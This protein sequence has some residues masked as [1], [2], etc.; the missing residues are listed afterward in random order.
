MVITCA[1]VSGNVP[2]V[3]ESKDTVLISSMWQPIKEWITSISKSAS[4]MN[5][6]SKHL[7]YS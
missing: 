2:Q 4:F 3:K 7:E 5:D 1:A 6:D